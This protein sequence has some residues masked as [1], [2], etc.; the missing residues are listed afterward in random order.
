MHGNIPGPSLAAPATGTAVC[1]RP[2]AECDLGER[3]TGA[4]PG[5]VVQERVFGRSDALLHAVLSVAG[6]AA[7]AGLLAGWVTTAGWHEH[8]VVFA[9][10]TLLLLGNLAIGQFRWFQLP[11]MA[12]PVPIAARPGWSV[13]VATTFV[14]DVEPLAMLEESVAALVALDYPH[15]TWVLDEGDDKRVKALC[16][17]LGARHFSRRAR[18]HYQAADGPF[19]ARSKHGNYNAWLYE[20]GFERYDIVVAFD[21]DHVADR[22][23]LAN[24]LGYFDDPEVGYVQAPQV[25]SNTGSSFIA[26]GAAEEGAPF[27]ACVQPASYAAGHPIIVGCHNTHRV[28]A[29][30][31]VGGFAPHDADDILLTLLYRRRRWKGVYVPR[32]LARG[33]APVDW[34]TYLRQQT[35]WA[36]ALVDLKVRV[37]PALSQGLPTGSR[38][39]GLLH[40]VTF[41]IPGINFPVL[42]AAIVSLE[43]TGGRFA[44]DPRPL[45]ACGAACAVV[46]L[47]RDAFQRRFA[48]QG[49]W[50]PLV[51]WRAWWL[52]YA[53]WP[54][55]LRAF[56]EAIL[57]H[58]LPY[59]TTPKVRGPRTSPL[60]L[61]PHAATIL[62]IGGGRAIGAATGA[63][64][65]PVVLAC[66]LACAVLSAVSLTTEFFAFPDPCPGPGCAARCGVGPS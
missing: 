16:E 30:K 33:L 40:G 63:E 38:L 1:L 25:Y 27:Y 52:A 48:P 58:R 11:S 31:Q 17:R 5:T 39:L 2:S 24:I 22:S 57:G 41:V 13:G 28:V 21:P 32:P 50:W 18:P 46:A 36:R 3:A 53:K 61:A 43:I 19:R 8:P 65:S 55:L 12:R 15:D 62:A 26:R 45:L 37:Y 42:L 49:Q 64:V 47:L 23:F 7:W 54:F 4:S 44:A 20:V 10:L 9:A 29:L 34:G 60:L 51:R 56:V 66:A 14:P 59:A 35:R 6:L